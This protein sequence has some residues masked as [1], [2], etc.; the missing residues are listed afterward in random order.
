MIFSFVDLSRPVNL[1]QSGLGD[2]YL[3]ND[4]SSALQNRSIVQIIRVMELLE[5]LFAQE[6]LEVNCQ[7]NLKQIN[8]TRD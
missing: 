3:Y 5:I 1:N 7:L 2:V 8:T 4:E 6:I